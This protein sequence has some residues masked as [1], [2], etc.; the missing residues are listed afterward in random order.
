MGLIRQFDAPALLFP[1]P[2]GIALP[3]A[4][5]EHGGPEDQL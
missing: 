5:A 4:L 1:V 3:E 2:L